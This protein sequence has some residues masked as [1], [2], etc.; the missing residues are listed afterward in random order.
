MYK[1]TLIAV[2]DMET[3]KS[4]YHDVLDMDVINDFGANVQLDGGLFLQTAD[5]WSDF[6]RGKEIHFK[7][8]AGELYFEVSDIDVFYQKLQ[9]MD[10]E[11]I[12]ELYEH[13]WGQ[14]VVRFYDPDH[15]VIEV[16]ED[17]RMVVKR[18]LASG[19]TLAETAKRM[20]VSV[21]YVRGCVD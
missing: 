8:N 9:R 6:I 12:H 5:T 14:R 21:D 2:S 11:Y 10:I 7:N 3:S 16:A 15:H 19:M 4:F 1:G 17:I 18:F 13:L 20:D